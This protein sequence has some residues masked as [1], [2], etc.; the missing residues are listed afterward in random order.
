MTAPVIT[1]YSRHLGQAWWFG[2][3]HQ[4]EGTKVAS[5]SL[6]GSSVVITNTAGGS[7][8]HLWAEHHARW[9]VVVET[10]EQGEAE[11]EEEEGG[12]GHGRE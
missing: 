12:E 3:S 4:T 1:L 5:C 8:S 9:V 6:Y 7:W 11:E 10:E 2:L